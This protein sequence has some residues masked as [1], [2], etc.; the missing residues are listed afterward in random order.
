[1]TYI[2]D[3]VKRNTQEYIFPCNCGGG[4]GEAPTLKAVIY[5]NWADWDCIITEDTVMQAK[6]YQFC[7]FIVCAWKTV[8]FY[9]DWPVVIKACNAFCNFGTIDLRG[10]K[11]VPDITKNFYM[12]WTVGNVPSSCVW[13]KDSCEVYWWKWGINLRW[14]SS[15]NFRWWDG[16]WQS[17]QWCQAPWDWLCECCRQC[18][19]A[20]WWLSCDTSWGWGGWGSGIYR[21]A[22]DWCAASNEEC[23]GNGWDWSHSQYQTR[24]AWWGWG[25]FGSVRWGNWGKW[26][27][28]NEKWGNG[29]MWWGSVTGTGWNGWQG[30]D[31]F[32][33]ANCLSWYPGNWG[34]GWFSLCGIWGTGG[35]AWIWRRTQ[36]NC[37][38][39]WWD[40][41]YWTWGAWGNWAYIY[42]CCYCTNQ[43]FSYWGKWGMSLFGTWGN[44][45]LWGSW[46]CAGCTVMTCMNW[47]SGWAWW[48]SFFWKW[49]NWGK[50]G[51]AS[52]PNRCWGNWGRGWD[53]VGWQYWLLILAN[54]WIN[55]KI[56]GK[57]GCWWEGWAWWCSPQ[58]NAA[59]LWWWVGWRW[60]NGW[61]WATVTVFYNNTFT[62]WTADLQWGAG[63]A[64]GTGWCNAC[65]CPN[66]S[67]AA[68]TSGTDWCYTVTQM[69]V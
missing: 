64:W 21:P 13:D 55:N 44:W 3:K 68:W 31:W 54:E 43:N 65:G 58:T 16:W 39:D 20:A 41:T 59:C 42:W 60:G 22:W 5:W 15:D 12:Y 38:W 45:W 28:W 67:W 37:W 17:Q 2:I 46:W 4:G 25:W 11:W 29:W 18:A 19:H 24:W 8:S 30:W 9:W 62:A 1:M 57:G 27:A 47:S 61:N 50:W 6:E 63:W 14:T 56:C 34:K 23:W 7:N 66:T 52:C 33:A 10:C 48:D 49:G 35:D 51:D 26:W 69:S 36:P 32:C 53:A 40:S